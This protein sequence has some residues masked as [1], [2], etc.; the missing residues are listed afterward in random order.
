M[1]RVVYIT[2]PSMHL[3][4][5]RRQFEEMEECDFLELEQ[6]LPA[7]Y[8]LICLIWSHSKHYQQPSRLVVL[9]QEISNLMIELV[10]TWHIIGY[11]MQFGEGMGSTEVYSIILLR[12]GHV[13]KRLQWQCPSQ[14]LYLGD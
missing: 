11:H 10:R 1:T 5:L 6:R 14:P 3:K 2:L 9:M 4:P 13:I 12:G 8:H 7:I